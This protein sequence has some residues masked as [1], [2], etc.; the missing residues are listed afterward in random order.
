[1]APPAPL[2]T[3]MPERDFQLLA[4]RYFG[5]GTASAVPPLFSHAFLSVTQPLARVRPPGVPESVWQDGM[6]RLEALGTEEG[7]GLWPEV[8]SGFE[9]LANRLKVQVH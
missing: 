3:P 4:E 7:E 8:V 9:G 6:A 2:S 5:I 1:M